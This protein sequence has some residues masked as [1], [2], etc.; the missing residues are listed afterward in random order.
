[1]FPAFGQGFSTAVLR[2]RRQPTHG[3]N[4]GRSNAWRVN[5]LSGRTSDWRERAACLSQNDIAVV[6]ETPTADYNLLK[7]ELHNTQEL[8]NDP[9]GIKQI[10]VGVVGNNLLNEDIRNHVS[11][12]KD[13]VLMPGAGVWAFASVRY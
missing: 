5:R 6:G 13:Q 8:N 3:L 12:T 1:V 7:V 10:S 2:F 9:M 4:G 11:S